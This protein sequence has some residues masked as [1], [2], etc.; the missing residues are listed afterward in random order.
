MSLIQAFLLGIIQGITEFL[1]ISSS[2]HL[3]L[4]Q[5]VFGLDIEEHI[6]FDLICHLG[7][8]CAIFAVYATKIKSLFSKES[9]MLK[10]ILIGTL[11]LFPIVFILKPIENVYSQPHLLGFSFLTTAFLLFAGIRWGHEK[12]VQEKKRRSFFDP[13]VIGLFQTIALLPGIS[14]SGSTISGARLLGWTRDEALTFSFLLAIPAILG[15]VA[16]KT[17]QLIFSEGVVLSDTTCIHYFIGF[18]TS[19]FVG[20]LALKELI[21]LAMKE[22]L[23]YFVWYCL[24]LGIG[25]LVY[26]S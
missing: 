13:L 1:P 19:F 4:G 15:G 23:M 21:K 2:G 20:Y 9:K 17:M 5:F 25:L 24:I 22:K 3:A 14:R 11:P 16:L 18:F 26:F 6:P 7:T 8:L 10:Q 12:T